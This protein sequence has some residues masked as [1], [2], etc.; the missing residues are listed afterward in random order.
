[1]ILL[2][3]SEFRRRHRAGERDRNGDAWQAD[4]QIVMVDRLRAR[5]QFD[6]HVGTLAIID[7]TRA[8]AQ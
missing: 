1:V 7:Q 4:Q 6:D 3:E 2:V 8:L 5:A